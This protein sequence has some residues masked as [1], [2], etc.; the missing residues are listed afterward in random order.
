MITKEKAIAAIKQLPENCDLE[1]M[2][3]QLILIEKIERAEEDIKKGNFVSHKDVKKQ[4][5]G[6]LK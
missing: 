6:W 1:A 3:E 2:I 5:A 4:M